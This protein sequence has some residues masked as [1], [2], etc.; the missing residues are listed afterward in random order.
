MVKTGARDGMS[1]GYRVEADEWRDIAGER[2]RIIRD[3]ALF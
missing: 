2:V 1:I 3:C